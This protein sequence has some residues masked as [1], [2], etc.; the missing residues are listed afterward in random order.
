MD[1]TAAV[2]AYCERVG[3]AFWA[4]PVNALTNAA[5]L[6]AA[7]WALR[8]WK[9]QPLRDGA[10]LVLI[11]V[12]ALVGIGSFL[13]HTLATRWAGLADG[14]RGGRGAP[15]RTSLTSW[16]RAALSSQV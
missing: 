6:V 10:T 1:W 15:V 14:T 8:Q 2:D 12:V 13:F 9:R 16:R 4:E 11:L 7:F 3:P 5:F